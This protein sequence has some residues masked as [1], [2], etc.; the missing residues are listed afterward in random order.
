MSNNCISTNGIICLKDDYNFIYKT[1][2]IEYKEWEDGNFFYHF[3]PLYNVIDLLEDRPDL[4]QGIPGLDLH[5][6]KECYIRENV[7]PVFISERTPGE[8]RED[9]YDLLMKHN[10]CSLNRLEWLIREKPVYSGDRLYVDEYLE[11]DDKPVISI[12]SMFD[13]IN[14]GK[15]IKRE[16]LKII[17]H[18]DYLDTREISINDINR[19]DYYR[20]LMP[21]C[22]HDF[23]IK[24]GLQARGIERAKQENKYTG[25]A[26]ISI[27]PLKF[28]EVMED[29]I[30]HIISAERAARELGVS[31]Y[32]FLR[33]LKNVQNKLL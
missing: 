2:R 31:R 5:L 15:E 25:R 9:L 12:D 32:T 21:M 11:I 6:R 29:Y 14:S 1:A 3:Y 7:V 33:R 18:G 13:L 4:F 28:K 20:L 8:N 26:E 19:L 16:L 27:D 10:M 30:N 17:C 24:R 22:I 23:R